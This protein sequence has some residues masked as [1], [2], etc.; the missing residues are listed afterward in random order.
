MERNSG[1]TY[2]EILIVVMVIGIL[3]VTGIS[4]YSEFNSRKQTESAAR[5]VV[6]Y[7]QLA[8]EKTRAHDIPSSCGSYGGFYYTDL[9]GSS[10]TLV[11]SGCSALATHNVGA[12][13]YPEGDFRVNFDQ[14]GTSASGDSCILVEHPRADFCGKVTIES[15]GIVSQ[16][17]LLKA[18]CT[19]P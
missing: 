1:F 9:T 7:V 16:E 3:A 13:V 8:Q 6:E 11:P 14:F 2:I 19:C 18:S 17:L 15:S 5:K 4:S 10:L 12:F